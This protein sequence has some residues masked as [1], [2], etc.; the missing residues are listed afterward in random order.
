MRICVV[1]TGY[2]GLVAGACFSDV[3]N[4]VSCLDID[5]KKIDKLNQGEIPIFEPGLED[6]VARNTKAGRL[7]FTTDPAEAIGSA[8]VIFLAVGTPSKP[9]GD[10]DL[11]YIL[12]A[13]E[14][15]RDNLKD[16]AFVV[17]KSTV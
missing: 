12:A 16:E 11:K 7:H 6:I 3:G 15:I 1:G 13:A 5:Q 8:R 10:L 4:H 14:S 2:V 17:L 9:D